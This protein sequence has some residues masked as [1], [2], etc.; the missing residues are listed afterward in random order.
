ML[1][2]L[3]TRRLHHNGSSNLDGVKTKEKLKLKIIIIIIIIKIKTKQNNFLKIFFTFPVKLLCLCCQFS[4][5][6]YIGD[7]LWKN[8]SHL[9]K[10]ST[11]STY[12]SK[13]YCNGKKMSMCQIMVVLSQLICDMFTVSVPLICW[14]DNLQSQILEKEG[15]RKKMREWGVLKSPCHRYL[16]GAPYY[17]SCQKILY[18]MKYGF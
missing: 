4:C 13:M 15:I 10:S 17:V 6:R 9:V 14:R 7:F 1:L 11:P 5:H 18:K 2:F 16:P 8:E 12:L 3:V